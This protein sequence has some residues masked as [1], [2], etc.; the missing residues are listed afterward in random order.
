MQHLLKREVDEH[1]WTPNL[2]LVFPAFALD[3]MPNFQ[4][5]IVRAI[6]D[7]IKT[8]NT[9]SLEG[10]Q[11]KIIAKAAKLLSY[12]PDIWLLSRKSAFSIAPSSNSQYRKARKELEKAD[13][14]PLIPENLQIILKNMATDLKKVV[15][16]NEDYVSESSLKIVDFRADDLFY[17]HKGYAFSLWQISEGLALDFKSLLMSAD[18]Y[19]EWIL[20]MSDLQKAAEFSPMIVRNGKPAS[21]TSPNHLLIQNYY[22]S[23]A[24]ADAEKIS[25]LLGEYFNATA[26]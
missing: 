11:K 18:A 25:N 21:L 14:F 3:N 20:L 17:I 7:N 9:F 1:I 13:G 26:D 16:E 24:R 23:A 22:L 15:K 19:A 12:P 8:I 10:D 5:G 6:R 4:T 2:P